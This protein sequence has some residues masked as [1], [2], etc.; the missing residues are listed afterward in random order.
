MLELAVVL[1][2]LPVAAASGWYVAR[3]QDGY[4]R[5]KETALSGS[6]FRGLNYLLN[7]QPDKAIEVFLKIAEIN[8]E[9]VETHLALGNLFRRRGEMDKA[10]RFHKHIITR[11]DLSDE[12]RTAAL[13][14]LG[15]DYMRAGLLDRAERLFSELLEHDPRAEL[16]ARQLLHIYQQEKDWEKAIDKARYLRSDGE[17]TDRLVAQFHCEI[18]Q[19]AL[20]RGDAEQVEKTLRQ[21]RHC[22]PRSAR[23]RLLQAELALRS[24]DWQAAADYFKEACELDSDCSIAV[25]DR[26]IECYRH[27]GQLESLEIWLSELV[28]RSAM[29]TPTIALA[30]LMA[31]A[32]PQNAVE[33]ML[34]RL[35]QRPTVRGLEYLMELLNQEGVSLDQVGPELI[36]ALMQRLL[37]G[38]PRYRCQHCGFSGNSAHWLCPS[39]RRWN[40]T[41]VINGVLGE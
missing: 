10:I 33:F 11:Q 5:R 23:P 30:R 3:R 31:E 9:T 17:K 38:Q 16:P 7:E 2:L 21:A 20:D 12:Q 1:A 13:F 27:L 8:K 34:G 36:R 28:D 29:S 15:E 25:M 40:T 24:Q 19:Q 35:A 39:C 26:L 32:K 22:D 4:R 37:E 14:E 6:Y 18:A 41:R